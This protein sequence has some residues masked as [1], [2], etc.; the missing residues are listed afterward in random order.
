MCSEALPDRTNSGLRSIPKAGDR[1]YCN[2]AALGGLDTLVFS[3]GIGEKAA[4]VRS[5]VCAGLGFLGIE[6]DEQRNFAN[7]A[8][9]SREGKAA[10]VRVMATDEEWMIARTV[11]RVLGILS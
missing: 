6:I 10:T 1:A 9:I 2:A 3:G 4:P 8:V 7:A 11:C 5:R